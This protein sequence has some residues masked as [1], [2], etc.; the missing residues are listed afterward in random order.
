MKTNIRDHHPQRIPFAHICWCFY[1]IPTHVIHI[2][3]M[4]ITDHSDLCFRAISSRL[5]NLL[6]IIATFTFIWAEN[7]LKPP[8]SRS[9]VIGTTIGS[10]T[11]LALSTTVPVPVVTHWTIVGSNV[12][13]SG[14]AEIGF[15]IWDVE[16]LVELSAL[17]MVSDCLGS[18]DRHELAAEDSS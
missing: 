14:F 10:W 1:Y 12:Y 3:N 4:T 8:G 15:L 2:K 18:E 9:I 13:A 5:H 17:R 6:L 11:G 16:G 7:V